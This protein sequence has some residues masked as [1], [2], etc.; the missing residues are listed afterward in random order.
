M[1]ATITS[2]EPQKIVEIQAYA[3]GPPTP[4][5]V[6]K[7]AP[8]G[9]WPAVIIALAAFIDK[10][11]GAITLGAAASLQEEFGFDDA[12]LGVLASAPIIASLFF[13]IPAG[14]WADT[15]NR[16]NMLTIVIICWGLC[17]LGAG[18]AI[19]LAMFTTFRILLGAATPL[20]IP[21]SSSLLGDF[22]PRRSRT[23]AFGI[24]RGLEN[25]GLPAGTLIGAVVGG[26]VGWRIAFFVVAVPALIL[27]GVLFF[28]LREPRRGVGDEISAMVEGAE[29]AAP[30]AGAMA[31]PLRTAQATGGVAPLEAA[32]PIAPPPGYVAM[33]PGASSQVTGPATSSVVSSPA[34]AVP[35][36]PEHG[37]GL[38]GQIEDVVETYGQPEFGPMTQDVAPDDVIMRPKGV[39]DSFR[40]V[41]R[42]KTVR[43]L[44][45]GQ[46]VLFSAFAGFFAFSTL[47]FARV[48][49]T[50]ES[51]FTVDGT[52]SL[53]GSAQ[54][55]AG[56]LVAGASIVAIGFAAFLATKIDER[57][58]ATNPSLRVTASVFALIAGFISLLVFVIADPLPIRLTAFLIFAGVNIIAV[59]NLSAAI[60]DTLPAYLRGAG[61]SVFQFL[62]AFGSAFGALAVGVGSA[63]F[64][65][66]LRFGFAVLLIPLFFGAVVVYRARSSYVEDSE[67]VI[68]GAAASLAAA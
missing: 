3:S 50:D 39:I 46:T 22:Y 11:E 38:G 4:M 67:R 32:P 20:N 43:R 54:A 52:A 1:S 62:L 6:A 27:A 9:W 36:G 58:A 16:K 40:I 14:R 15:R 8:F 7:P 34:G 45:F 57:F 25:I 12:F 55:A 51:L 59:T 35:P 13:V 61:F 31:P 65:N 47:F 29:A 28:T 24:L 26:L 68:K 64:D 53:P 56:A 21:P 66:N 19:S 41:F 30:V 10:A 42:I 33:A 49:F 37:H 48:Y 5:D 60:A 44:V 17:T 18:A 63:L 2:S 23:K